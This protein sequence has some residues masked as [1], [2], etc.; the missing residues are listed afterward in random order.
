VTHGEQDDL[1]AAIQEA[2]N[3]ALPKAVED[4]MPMALGEALGPLVNHTMWKAIRRYILGSVLGYLILAAGLG[5]AIHDNRARS[6]AGR[7]V[8]CKIITQGDSTSYAYRAEGTINDKQL[9]RAL[10]QSAEYRKQLGPAPACSPAITAP[11]PN[12]QPGSP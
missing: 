3:D 7:A 8:L 9:R 11:P 4:A 10:K 12:P 2:V 6:T 1:H 5:Y